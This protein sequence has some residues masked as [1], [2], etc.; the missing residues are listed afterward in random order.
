MEKFYIS[1]KIYGNAAQIRLQNEKAASI[2]E[3]G[4]ASMSDANIPIIEVKTLKIF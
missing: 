4:T 1:A 3:N 2:A